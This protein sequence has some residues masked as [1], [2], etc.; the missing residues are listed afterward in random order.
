MWFSKTAERLS[1]LFYPVTRYLNTIGLVFLALMMFLTAADVVGRYIFNTP[2]NGAFELT[3][4]MM[5]VAIAF[6]LSY[7]QVKKGHVNVDVVIVK[8]SKRVQAI[9]NSITCLLFFCLF[10][11]IAW[12]LILYAERLRIGERT[13]ASL[14]IPVFPFIDLVALGSIILCLVLI[15]DLL[16]SL[17]EVTI[18]KKWWNWTGMLF[19]IVIVVFIFSLPVWGQAFLFTIDPIIAGYL[20]IGFLIVMMF[21]GMPVG[22]VMG[23]IGFLGIAY[24]GGINPALT[25]IGTTPYSTAAS[26]S[27]SVVPLFILMGAFTYYTGMTKELFDTAQAWLGRLP[28][29]LALATIGASA[30]FA[31]VSGSSV[32]A[33]ATIGMV[34]LPEMRKFKYSDMLSTGAIAAGGGLAIMIPPSTVLVIYGIL[35][36]TSIGKLLLAGFVPGIILSL[37][38]MLAIFAM[39][40]RNPELG[41][42]GI[43][44]SFI[45]KIVSF[46]STWAV[47]LLFLL[48]MGGLYAGW[49]TPTEGAGIGAFGAFAIGLIRRRLKWNGFVDSLRETLETS[50][51]VFVILIGANIFGYF[52]AVTRV[53]NELSASIIGLSLNPNLIMVVILVVYLFLGCIMS[54]L[55]MIVLTIPI[56]F[57]IVVALGFDP[58]WFGVI[59]V[60]VVEMGQ[61]T[62]PVGINVYIIHGIA[63]SV[64]MYTIFRG[65]IPF[66][67]MEFVLV[68]LLMIWPGIA[69]FLP[70]MM[71]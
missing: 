35:T 37:L 33:T 9:I 12:R 68:V 26:Y 61:L 41:P 27:M 29:G 34:A 21:S 51:M 70:A 38:Y 59:I 2:L 44:T 11:L 15:T 56:F 62:P 50:A 63:K 5:A 55:A 28:G 4:F 69:T 46:R 65:V 24:V 39:C 58:I 14:Y 66:L 52:L 30:A 40:L 19:L 60:L 18:G 10:A 32:A 20:G 54:S 42:K 3:E 45:Q 57:P 1:D 36:E 23:L 7:T 47:F 67:I 43:K 64:P 71:K 22:I 31:A 8:F 16:R 13:S 53:P 6:G 48:V 17:A 49:F 25:S